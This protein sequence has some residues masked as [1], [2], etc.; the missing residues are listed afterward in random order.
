MGGVG[1]EGLRVTKILAQLARALAR[2]EMNWQ[3]GR[4]PPQAGRAMIFAQ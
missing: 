4:A 2:A 1:V 3:V